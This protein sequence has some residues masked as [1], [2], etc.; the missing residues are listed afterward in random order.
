MKKYVKVDCVSTFRQ[1]YM[2]PWDGLQETNPD[3]E[4]NDKLAE[5]WASDTV[6]SE[7]CNEFSQKYLGEHISSIDIITEDEMIEAFDR[8]N[9]LLISEWSRER[10]IAYVANWNNVPKKPGV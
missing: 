6:V 7:E 4:L 1:T 3:V 2:I 10:K 5:E 8:D 9:P